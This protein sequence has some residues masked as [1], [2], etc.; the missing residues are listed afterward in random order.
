V[1]LAAIGAGCWLALCVLLAQVVGGVFLGHQ[2]LAAMEVPLLGMLGLVLVRGGLLW[3]GEVAAQR[4]ADAL[5]HGLRAR[6]AAR[7][8]AL[9]PAYTRGQRAG[10]LVYV[11]GEAVEALDAYVTRYL[12][13][14]ALSV[15]VPLLVALLVLFLDPWA[16]AILLFAWPVLLLLLALIGIR[17]RDLTE[18]RERELAWMN[19]H[20]LDMLRGLPTLELFGRS[21]DAAATIQ[22]VSTRHAAATMDVLRTAFQ[23]SLVLEWGA[24]GATAMVAIETSVRVMSGGLPFDHALAALLLAPEFF[25]PL[26]KLS[27]EYHA[28]RAGAAAASRTHALLDLPEPSRGAGG[29]RLPS[30]HDLRFEDVCVAY[31]RGA[32]PALRGFSLEV[33][34][35][36]MVALVGATGA[37]KSTVAELLLRFVEPDGGGVEVGGT[38]LP[39]LDPRMWRTRVAW[40][41]QHPTLFHGTVA[42]NIRLARPEASDHEV[43]AAAEAAQAHQFI[44]DLP[45]GYGA[46]VGEGGARLS[47]GERQRLALARAF[48]KDAP[49][50]ILDE[51]TSHLDEGSQSLVLD[52]LDRLRRGRTV[53][54]IAHR[55]EVAAAADLVAVMD[56][57]RV[58]EVRPPNLAPAGSAP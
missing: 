30:R 44:L 32:R 25:L 47:G 55:L 49:L 18:R 58:V 12:P 9:G 48:L 46:G 20:F 51:A 15:V 27:L 2:T 21:G 38:P 31:D 41:P 56:A 11:A 37:G 43:V 17:V 1:L 34:D 26:R 50:L 53:L 6:I 5:K 24:V 54:L 22:R 23:S 13:A 8:V 19:A 45:G 40:V 42:E 57:G 3:G 33:A 36:Q 39:E 7:L 10:E 16:L 28:G 35:G 52:A 14:R 29:R 4:A